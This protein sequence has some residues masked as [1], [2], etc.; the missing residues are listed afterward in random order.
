MKPILPT[1]TKRLVFKANKQGVVIMEYRI[2][3]RSFTREQFC[4]ALE[5]F[6]LSEI[7]I[8][9][10]SRASARMAHSLIADMKESLGRAILYMPDFP[11]YIREY[12]LVL[13]MLDEMKRKYEMDDFYPLPD[14]SNQIDLKEVSLNFYKMAA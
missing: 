14:N 11:R 13:A 6:G 3:G 12:D 8:E 2:N 4:H 1:L 7:D 5:K 10:D 9:F